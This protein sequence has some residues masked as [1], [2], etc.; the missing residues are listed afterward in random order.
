M[1]QECREL[2]DEVSTDIRTLSYV[3]HPPLLDEAGLSSAARWFVDGFVRRSRI[4]VDLDLPHDMGRMP[5]DLELTLFRILQESLTNVHRHAN[6]PNAFVKI[7]LNDNAVTLEVKDEGH[8]AKP[9]V[10]S[11]TEKNIELLGVGVR[12]MQERVRQLGGRLE[13]RSGSKG[14]VMRAT[15]PLTQASPL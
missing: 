7:T 11:S 1:L 12:G 13:L 8:V 14:T 4:K 9:I 10:V 6:S 3:L 2:A 5:Q 15:L